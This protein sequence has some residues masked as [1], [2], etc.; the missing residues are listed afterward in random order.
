MNGAGPALV[1]I[2][3]IGLALAAEGCDR[4]APPAPTLAPAPAPMAGTTPLD[5]SGDAR[6]DAGGEP[7]DDADDA[8]PTDARATTPDDA[9]EPTLLAPDGAALPQTDALPSGDSSVFSLHARA[10]WDAIATD[11]PVAGERAFF[12]LVAYEQV[13]AIPNPAADWRARLLAA[14]A[15]DVHAY[16]GRLTPG[17]RLVRI[18]IPESKAR[19]M[20]PGSEG[21]KLGYDRVL[22]ARLVWADAQGD[23]HTLPIKSMIS[24]R[25]EWYVVHLAG[26]K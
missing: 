8:T 11:A 20:E 24:W 25:G 23:E 4:S 19:W 5:A 12:P 6:T 9:E 17:A 1:A 10:L 26:F 22:D 16:H 7:T 13:K 18:D 3:A 14:F 15:R 21:N 2:V